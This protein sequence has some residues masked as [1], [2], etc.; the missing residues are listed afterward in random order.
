MSSFKQRLKVQAS[1]ALLF[2]IIFVFESK[3]DFRGKSFTPVK[4]TMGV[5]FKLYSKFKPRL[6]T[7]VKCTS[8]LYST[9][10][11]MYFTNSRLLLESGI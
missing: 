3:Y 4:S 2:I 9:S 11:V 5:F 7:S 6:N 8:L 1:K 10:G